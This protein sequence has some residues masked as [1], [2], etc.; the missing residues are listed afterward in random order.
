M[1]QTLEYL[2]YEGCDE[3]RIMNM[4][5]VSFKY[6]QRANVNNRYV[7]TSEEVKPFLALIEEEKNITAILDGKGPKRGYYQK[8][9]TSPGMCVVF[10]SNHLMETHLIRISKDLH[11]LLDGNVTYDRCR[12]CISLHD[13]I[14]VFYVFLL[15]F[16]IS[17]FI[18]FKQSSYSLC[19]YLFLH[20]SVYLF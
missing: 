5:N 3:F 1:L 9:T 15:L 2:W 17:W 12:K 8:H 7:W 20:F 16:Y 4:Y 19:I 13:V 18:Y 10:R 6:I 14:F 11:H